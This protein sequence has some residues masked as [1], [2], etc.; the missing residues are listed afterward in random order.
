MNSTEDH[1]ANVVL[2]QS[3][4]LIADHVNVDC[5]APRFYQKQCLSLKQLQ[6]L[7]NRQGNLTD[8][9]KKEYLLNN[10]LMNGGGKILGTLLDALDETSQ[11]LQPHANLAV[12]LREQYHDVCNQIDQKSE[13][14]QSAP[15][16][17][18][19][20][21]TTQP[22]PQIPDIIP[23]IVSQ[24][25]HSLGS[26]APPVTTKSDERNHSSASGPACNFLIAFSG[27][28]STPYVCNSASL[29][30]DAHIDHMPRQSTS[31]KPSQ[32]ESCTVSQLSVC[33]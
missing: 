28:L 1:A 16:S 30:D 8:Q 17:N 19:S 2:R 10:V 3:H 7:Q 5:I 32:S 27:S 4:Q 12:R 31:S 6:Y 29:N 33:T 24:L 25:T 18:P 22:L 14:P 11:Q 21:N 20:T 15:K 9:G 23:Q 13:E 26:T